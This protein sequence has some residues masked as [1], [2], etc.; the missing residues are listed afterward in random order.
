MR[1]STSLLASTLFLSVSA[2][3]SSTSESHNAA[4]EAKAASASAPAAHGVLDG[5]MFDV[6]LQNGK[7]GA[8]PDQL[9]F[10]SASFDSSACR[11]YGFKPAKYSG[12][13]QGDV[14]TFEATAVSKDAGTNAWTGTV[15]GST[16]KGTLTCT[17]PKGASTK[18]T[19]EGKL[20][21]GALDGKNFEIEL[22]GADGKTQDK[23]RVSFAS[24]S[25]DS[26]SCRPFGFIRTA[27]T[28]T[29]AGDSTHFEATCVSTDYPMNHWQGT[30]HGDQIEG[31]LKSGEGADAPVL[32][33]KGHRV[34]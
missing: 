12:R 30:I 2:A 29:A 17:D 13:A 14:I 23:D 1:P 6:Q 10:D 34:L 15:H 26:T 25:F 7:G 27:Y 18:Y 28:T 21:S 19:Y 5:K 11:A 24:G 22:V 33:F 31:T 8:D 20:S 4:A 16:V 32:K 3:C 9:A